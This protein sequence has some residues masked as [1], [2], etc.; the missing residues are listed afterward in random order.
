M[1]ET[2][3]NGELRNELQEIEDQLKTFTDPTSGKVQAGQL[4]EALTEKVSL[5]KQVLGLEKRLK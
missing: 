3:R 5:L 1:K 4:K 2:N